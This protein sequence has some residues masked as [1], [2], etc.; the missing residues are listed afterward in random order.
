MKAH[1]TTLV[2]V[3]LIPIF[4]FT[5]ES[6]PMSKWMVRSGNSEIGSS[7]I[8]LRHGS[9]VYCENIDKEISRITVDLLWLNTMGH[10]D[11][12]LRLWVTYDDDMR[13]VIDAKIPRNTYH[14]VLNF[15]L[16]WAKG[17]LVKGLEFQAGGSGVEY[18]VTE[19]L[20]TL[21]TPT[22]VFMSQSSFGGAELYPEAR[23]NDVFMVGWDTPRDKRPYLTNVK[24]TKINITAN[25][26]SDHPQAAGTM[27]FHLTGENGHQFKVMEQKLDGHVTSFDLILEPSDL[28][29]LDKMFITFGGSGNHAA[30]RRIIIGDDAPPASGG[31]NGLK[32]L[33]DKLEAF[34]EAWIKSGTVGPDKMPELV[35]L[36]QEYRA[37]E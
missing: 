5:Q 32:P 13:E 29:R 33:N 19:V 18:K 30:I 27:K 36:L 25:K 8:L 23:H 2:L 24:S 34:L 11:V 15:D 16:K 22:A 26:A 28:E 21:A 10:V 35:K 9:K 6:V 3:F 12:R 17:K 31:C 37:K 7:S 14:N 1:F 4:A 20:L